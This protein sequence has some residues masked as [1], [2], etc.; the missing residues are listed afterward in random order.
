MHY[1]ISSTILGISVVVAYYVMLRSIRQCVDLI[2][3]VC[4]DANEQTGDRRSVQ[5]RHLVDISSSFFTKILSELF[6]Y[7]FT[8]Y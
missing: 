3:N 2:S 6:D 1:I 4:L 7:L 8:E 5:T